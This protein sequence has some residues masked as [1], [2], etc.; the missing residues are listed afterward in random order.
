MPRLQYS[1]NIQYF[2][3]E[4]CI[5]VFVRTYLCNIST[6]KGA[7][8][9]KDKSIE[10]IDNTKNIAYQ[11]KDISSKY[12]ASMHGTAF[13]EALGI[14]MAPLERNEPTELP[15]IEVSNMMMDNLFLL[16]DGTYIIIDYES[17]YLEENKIKYTNY[18]ARLM[19]T[20]YNRNKK[21]P[22]IQTVVIYT[23]DVKS[24]TT[25]PIIPIG[26]E[27]Y[28]IQEIFLSSWDT[29]R[30]I[31]DIEEKVEHRAKLTEVDQIRLMMVSLSVEGKDAKIKTIRKCINIIEVIDDDA[32]Q[33]KLYGGL[34][35]FTDKIIDKRNWERIRR[36]VD[37]TKIEQIFY[38]EK[39]EAINEIAANLLSDGLP[40]DKVS[41]YTGLDLSV[42]E[43][44][45]RRTATQQKES[46]PV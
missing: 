46:V 23:A 29:E 37:M 7:F 11:N 30:I 25:N 3:W 38:D 34:I 15:A 24:G 41:N 22:E 2:I 4:M 21:F 8:M 13:A 27:K 39:M 31:Q 42:V 5:F 28:R 36:K 33:M 43:E 18:L 32:L 26:K 16:A 1:C 9:E 19:K 40:I 17:K 35:A 45:A 44:I 20:L 10:S 14:D 12:L 6:Q